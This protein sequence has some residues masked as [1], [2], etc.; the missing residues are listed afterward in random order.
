MAEPHPRGFIKHL[1]SFVHAVSRS[2]ALLR[3]PARIFEHERR[4]LG[5]PTV[6]GAFRRLASQRAP[7]LGHSWASCGGARPWFSPNPS[8]ER[9]SQRPLA[10]FGPPLMSN[11]RPHSCP[12]APHAGHIAFFWSHA[13]VSSQRAQVRNPAAQSRLSQWSPSDAVVSRPH[14]K[15]S[16]HRAWVKRSRWKVRGPFRSLPA[17]GS[18]TSMRIELRVKRHFEHSFAEGSEARLS[19]GVRDQC[20]GVGNVQ[21]LIRGAAARS[22]WST[23][24][25]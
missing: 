22:A 14:G 5:T 17:H 4:P 16:A 19:G 2:E 7:R 20:F 8:I 6:E 25:A 3:E 1:P 10:P 12:P 21:R 24:K 13:P 15:P 23:W 9:T 18:G 11:V